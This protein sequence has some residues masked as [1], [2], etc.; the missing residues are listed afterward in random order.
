MAE[1]KRMIVYEIEVQGYEKAARKLGR[2]RGN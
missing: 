2:R 1:E